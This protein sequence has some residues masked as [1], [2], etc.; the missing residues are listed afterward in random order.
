ME[1]IKEN[2][3]WKNNKKGQVTIFMILGVLGLVIV[4]VFVFFQP[5]K[6][7]PIEPVQFNSIQFYLD[8]CARQSLKQGVFWNGNQGGY[9]EPPNTSIYWFSTVYQVPLYYYQNENYLPD[10]F[11]FEKEA[12]KYVE[13]NLN[14]TCNFSVFSDQG[15]IIKQKGPI[16]SE[17]KLTD[18]GFILELK[19][20]LEVS[21][22][23]TYWETGVVEVNYPVKLKKIH[24]VA[25]KII[26]DKNETGLLCLNC[27]SDF[28]D[29]QYKEFFDNNYGYSYMTIFDGD[30]Q[31]TF[32]LDKTNKTIFDEW[33]DEI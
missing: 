32:A 26:N 16:K 8:N 2:I 10:L 22:G 28:G 12:N 17:T 1:Q 31:F 33:E 27:L 29:L 13:D 5:A 14:E 15:Y 9:Y 24:Q 18:Y 19:Y 21:L 11:V 4:G 30:Y 20:P 25:K 23:S 7:Q 6:Y 3:Q